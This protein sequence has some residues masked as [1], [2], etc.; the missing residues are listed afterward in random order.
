M[1]REQPLVRTFNS[2]VTELMVSAMGCNG[3][4][5]GSSD[6]RHVVRLHTHAGVSHP[7]QQAWDPIAFL[8]KS[9]QA[10]FTNEHRAI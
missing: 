10:R 1:V 6:N 2:V 5:T 8:K 4:R 7:K 3:K 9:K